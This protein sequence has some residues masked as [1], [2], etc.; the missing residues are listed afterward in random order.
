MRFER[1][2]L[3]GAEMAAV[4]RGRRRILALFVRRDQAIGDALATCPL[5][6]GGRI[7]DLVIVG[8]R[9]L[10]SAV[11]RRLERRP[12]VLEVV[13]VAGRAPG[14]EGLVMAPARDAVLEDPWRIERQGTV[15]GFAIGL[16]AVGEHQHMPAGFVLEIIEDPFFFKQPADEIEIALA[17]LHAVD[18][19]L[20][21][22]CQ[23]AGVIVAEA[24]FAEDLSGDVD[25]RLLLEHPAI[26]PVLQKPQPGDHDQRIG[27]LLAAHRVAASIAR[28]KAVERPQ[29]L[30][31]AAKVPIDGLVDQLRRIDRIAEGAHVERIG[32]ER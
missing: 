15:G 12:R 13:G 18:A 26:L 11:A 16:G 3:R 9:N 1:E 10:R 19:W 28:D 2:A 30:I 24:E 14:S 22:L 5:A 6:V 29:R 8:F 20:I 32:I 21:S 27:P 17:I 31:L 7:V 4:A 23:T 25:H